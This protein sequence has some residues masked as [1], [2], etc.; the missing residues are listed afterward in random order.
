MAKLNKIVTVTA[1]S[2]TTHD[3]YKSFFE[4]ASIH[5]DVEQHFAIQLLQL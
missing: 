4:P 1:I 5:I 2:M 3:D